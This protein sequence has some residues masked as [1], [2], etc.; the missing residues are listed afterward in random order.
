MAPLIKLPSGEFGI[1]TALAILLD[2]CSLVRPWMNVNSKFVSLEL[3]LAELELDTFSMTWELSEFFI[4]LSWISNRIIDIFCYW[5]CIPYSIQ[6]IK[7]T[8]T[9]MLK[10]F[11][12]DLEA[13]EASI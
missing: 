2:H 13:L 1:V 9:I 3:A 12:S 5:Y 8:M 7:C 10:I 4:C 6:S 11:K